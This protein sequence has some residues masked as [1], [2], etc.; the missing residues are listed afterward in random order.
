MAISNTLASRTAWLTRR[1]Q[2]VGR[3]QQSGKRTAADVTYRAT[4]KGSDEA[5]YTVHHF[6]FRIPEVAKELP[7][8]EIAETD[9]YFENRFDHNALAAFVLAQCARTTQKPWWQLFKTTA[10]IPC[11][12]RSIALV[13]DENDPESFWLPDFPFRTGFWHGAGEV[14]VALISGVLFTVA[15]A[16]VLFGGAVPLFR[17]FLGAESSQW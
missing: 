5:F 10:S 15:C 6:R 14:F 13:Y 8:I 17:L 4:I 7:E 12:R 9:S 11:T 2:D 16:V 1:D 3:L